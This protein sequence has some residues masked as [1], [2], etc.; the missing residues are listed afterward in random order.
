MGKL[1]PPAECN[2]EMSKILGFHVPSGTRT[3]EA[4]VSNLSPADMKISADKMV[5]MMRKWEEVTDKD[6]QKLLICTLAA[7][8]FR[9]FVSPYLPES[10]VFLP[11][12]YTEAM[13]EMDARL[14]KKETD[15]G[16]VT[17]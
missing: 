4:T 6:E 1:I 2:R 14:N 3:N 12:E 7:M 9:V 13:Q 17:S 5:A 15:N 16:D 8:G 11:V 10:T